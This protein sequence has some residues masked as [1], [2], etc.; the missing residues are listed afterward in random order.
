MNTGPVQG[1]PT[2]CFEKDNIFNSTLVITPATCDD[3][4][5]GGSS[6]SIIMGFVFY[7]NLAAMPD[8]LP[9]KVRVPLSVK[10]GP[11]TT[12]IDS[13]PHCR[14]NM[15]SFLSDLQDERLSAIQHALW[16]GSIPEAA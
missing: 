7:A 5:G 4:Q 1:P 11:E 3:W 16:T 9:G 2:G 12:K 8:D 13:N 15:F 10:C 14:V 6:V